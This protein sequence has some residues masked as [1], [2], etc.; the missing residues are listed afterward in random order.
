MT[1]AL[2]YT[3]ADAPGPDASWSVYREVYT[4]IDSNEPLDGLTVKV[5]THPTEEAADAEANRLQQGG[6]DGRNLDSLFGLLGG[7][8]RRLIFQALCTERDRLRVLEA[9]GKATTDDVELASTL[10]EVYASNL[11]ADE[12][13]G[14]LKQTHAYCGKT[15]ADILADIEEEGLNHE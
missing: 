4:S 2:H 6:R 13:C 3:S 7:P 9:E 8:A 5:S 10:T 12:C 11:V 15:P 14:I 1:Y